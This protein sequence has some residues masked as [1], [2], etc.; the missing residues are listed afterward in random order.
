[1]LASA[2]LTKLNKVATVISN[3]L[4]Y[5]SLRT[6]RSWIATRSAPRGK[7]RRQSMN[8]PLKETLQIDAEHI[9]PKNISCQKLYLGFL[10]MRASSAA[11]AEDTEITSWMTYTR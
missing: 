8:E 9:P 6:L 5:S 10:R 3:T 7:E 2:A 11:L 4:P 1:V